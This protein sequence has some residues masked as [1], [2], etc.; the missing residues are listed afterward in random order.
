MQDRSFDRE[1]EPKAD[2]EA[3][4]PAIAVTKRQAFTLMNMLWPYNAYLSSRNITQSCA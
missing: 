2:G 4:R 1:D 3:A